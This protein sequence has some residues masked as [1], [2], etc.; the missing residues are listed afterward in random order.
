MTSDTPRLRSCAIYKENGKV[1]FLLRVFTKIPTQLLNFSV[2][3]PK[4]FHTNNNSQNWTQVILF[5][6]YGH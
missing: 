4:I 5:H 6:T 3:F 2:D 1:R